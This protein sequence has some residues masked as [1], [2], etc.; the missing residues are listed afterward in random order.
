M[1]HLDQ[2]TAFDRVARE[3]S[4]S[5]AAVSLG[6]GQPAVSARIL[7]LEESVGGALFA[8]GRRIRLT[9]LG[10]S[11]LPFARRALEVVREGME[12]SRL[13]QVGERG[14]LRIGALGSLAGEV[15][16]PALARFLRQHPSV[17]V[18]VKS[19]HHEFL[20]EL[21]ADGIVDAALTVWPAGGAGLELQPIFK[22]R[23]R[24][25]LAA[26]PSHPLA[27]RKEVQ[28]PDVA[29]LAQ[30][31]L[32]LRWWRTHHPRI[33][34]L[35]DE[36]RTAIDVSMEAA[37][38]LVVEG[39]GAGFFPEKLVA[40]DLARGTLREVRVRGLELVRESALV[41]RRNAPMSPALASFIDVLRRGSR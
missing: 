15:I 32:R 35:A 2:L 34:A 23:E 37:R 17:E 31:L 27:R 33:T 41:R 25:V 16:G 11:F 13:A 22:L 28:Q 29:R 20:L 19:G 38:R 12:V 6:L 9:A 24:V 40:E 26:A 10:E 3:G 18:T 30:P 4:F 7:A 14:A 8:R 21:L 5:R 1:L 36:S 39:T